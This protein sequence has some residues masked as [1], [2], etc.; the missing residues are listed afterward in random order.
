MTELEIVVVLGGAAFAGGCYL[1]A[2]GLEHYGAER[3]RIIARRFD[4]SNRAAQQAAFAVQS[5]RA[6]HSG[7]QPL[8]RA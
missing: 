8:P 4:D 5:Q 1:I 6:G 3:E 2:L 7:P